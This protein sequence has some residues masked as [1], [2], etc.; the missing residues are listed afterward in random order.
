MKGCHNC[1][2]LERS[3][4][5][6]EDHAFAIWE[7]RR[8][9][10]KELDLDIVVSSKW[11]YDMVKKSPLTKHFKRVHTIP[12]GIDEKLFKQRNRQKARSKLRI[13]NDDFVIMFRQSGHE[14]KGLSYIKE[15]LKRLN[16]KKNIVLITVGEKGLLDE[17]KKKYQIIEYGW[18]DDNKFLVDLY[19]A[20]DLFLM[21]SIAESFGLMAVEAMSCSLPVIVFEGTALPEVTFSP[22]CGIS[23]KKGKTKDFVETVERLAVSP[24]ECLVRGKKGREIVEEHYRIDLYHDRI[25]RLYKDVIKRSK[26]GKGKYRKQVKGNE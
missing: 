8:Q 15:M 21:P 11:M 1:P 3:A 7:L 10:Y 14:F 20:A 19:S 6:T 24:K 26:E 2:Y 18:I 17:Y 22:E 16:S 23:L 4:P 9:V 12:F 25:I 13:A 5:L